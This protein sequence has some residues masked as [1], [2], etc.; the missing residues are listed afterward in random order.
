MHRFLR[1]VPLLLLAIPA[2]LAATGCNVNPEMTRCVDY[3]D[4]VVADGLCAQPQRTTRV[5]GSSNAVP[6][7]RRY[8][9][10]FG[11]YDFG[12]TAWGG[13]DRP[14]D[15]HV[16]ENRARPAISAAQENGYQPYVVNPS[17]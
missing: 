15:G 1:A 5:R 7:Y 11:S 2:G 13:S 4:Q 8:Y 10:G 12:S 17:R 16:Y 14:L 6:M 3:Q 9:G